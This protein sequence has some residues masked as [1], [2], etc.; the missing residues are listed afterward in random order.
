MAEPDP[1]AAGLVRH[2]ALLPP[3]PQTWRCALCREPE[4][5]YEV[6]PCER[7]GALM[8]WR[9]YWPAALSDAERMAAQAAIDEANAPGPDTGVVEI[10]AGHRH[11]Q[12]PVRGHRPCDDFFG[13]LIILCPGCRS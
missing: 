6:T 13:G 1:I 4:E 8:H 7:C 2:A 11:F 12:V 10:Q 3:T 5:P 9:C